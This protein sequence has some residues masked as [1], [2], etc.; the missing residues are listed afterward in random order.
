MTAA[1]LADPTAAPPALPPASQAGAG[2]AA[3]APDSSSGPGA[4]PSGGQAG[5]ADLPDEALFTILKLLAP[6][7]LAR[8]AAACTLLRRVNFGAVPGLK[9]TLY[10]HQVRS[11]C[12][13]LMG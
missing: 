11:G 5:L 4:A 10:P 13:W 12:C 3:V 7:D 8:A 1:Q 9:L 2:A 6:R